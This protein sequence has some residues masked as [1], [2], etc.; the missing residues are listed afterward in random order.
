[1]RT[2]LNNQ[3]CSKAGS[4]I[5]EI[6]IVTP[7]FLLLAA[8]ML[9]AISCAR[10]DILFSQAVDQVTQE[11]A[12]AVPVAGAGIDIA[13]EALIFINNASINSDKPT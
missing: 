12:V 7:V 9:T 3:F 10:A 11:L 5:L 4:I 2:R 1:M 6:A 8:F 13:G